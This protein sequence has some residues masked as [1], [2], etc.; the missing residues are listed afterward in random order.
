ME[1]FNGQHWTGVDPTYNQRI[2]YGYVKLAHGRDAADC[3]VNRGC[4]R[5]AAIEEN[6]IIVTLEELT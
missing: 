2:D 4:Y 3:P 1:I 6:E 5:N